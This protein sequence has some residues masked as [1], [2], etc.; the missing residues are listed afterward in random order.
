MGLQSRMGSHG[1]N[2]TSRWELAKSFLLSSNTQKLVL[3]SAVGRV[4]RVR[5]ERQISCRKTEDE[6]RMSELCTG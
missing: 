1:R 4:P 5:E 6:G 3:Y 2:L